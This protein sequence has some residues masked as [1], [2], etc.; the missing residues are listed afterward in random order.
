MITDNREKTVVDIG[1]KEMTID[2][3]FTNLI[4]CFKEKD[5][6]W[7]FRKFSTTSFYIYKRQSER[8]LFSDWVEDK[9]EFLLCDMV[10]RV[11]HY[12]NVYKDGCNVDSF[13]KTYDYMGTE[14]RLN[15]RMALNKIKEIIFGVEECLTIMN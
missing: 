2:D 8:T 7:S 10:T 15:N 13:T 4:N 12:S 14:E 5:L 11:H 3:V 1:I 9:I 6:N